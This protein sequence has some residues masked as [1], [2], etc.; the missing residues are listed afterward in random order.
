MTDFLDSRVT[1]RR[2]PRTAGID[3]ASP[4]EIVQELGTVLHQRTGLSASQSNY[5]R[6]Y[7]TRLGGKI[8]F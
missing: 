6:I 2:N 8:A 5:P 3:V 1:E 7:V 4:L